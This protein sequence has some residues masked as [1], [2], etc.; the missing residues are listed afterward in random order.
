MTMALF[1]S[2][3]AT[4]I[5]HF[6]QWTMKEQVR[7]FEEEV[8]NNRSDIRRLE[9][10]VRALSKNNTALYGKELGSAQRKGS[11]SKSKPQLHLNTIVWKGSGRLPTQIV[12]A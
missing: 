5:E 7:N 10:E 9:E 6:I 3:T 4:D 11:F 8:F 12:T 2:P 1:P